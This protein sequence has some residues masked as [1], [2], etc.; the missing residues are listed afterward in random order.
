MTLDGSFA[1]IAAMLWAFDIEQAKDVKPMYMVVVGV[2][3]EPKPFKIKLKPRG[4]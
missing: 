3:T 1:N 4:P 2:M